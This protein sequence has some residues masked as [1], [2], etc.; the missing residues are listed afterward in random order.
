M[1]VIGISL[2][3]EFSR[4]HAQAASRLAAWLA[5]ADAAEW[6]N[7]SD[8]KG[9]Y[10]SA[11]ILSENRVVFNIG[12]NSYRLLVQINYEAGIVLIEKVGTHR[13]YDR[14]ELG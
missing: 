5:E 12:G 13:E 3:T 6:Q 4:R 10:P 2:L 14:W 8:I 11:S 1:Q 9:R 7:P